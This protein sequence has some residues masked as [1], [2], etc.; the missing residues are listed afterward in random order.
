MG[1]LFLA[2]NKED[3]AVKMYKDL[4]QN[5][6]ELSKIGFVRLADLHKNNREYGKA[7]EFYE[8]AKKAMEKE[9]YAPIQFNVAECFEEQHNFDAAIEAYLGIPYLNESDTVW[10]VK[11]LLRSARIYEDKDNWGEAIKIYQ[12]VTTY[13]VAEAKYAQEKVNLLKKLIP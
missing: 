1:D 2:Q 3:Q 10:V 7:I 8:K 13:P 11:G 12:K 5:K 4:I 9:S 6:N